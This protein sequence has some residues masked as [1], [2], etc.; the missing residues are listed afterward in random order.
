MPCFPPPN[1]DPGEPEVQRLEK[2]DESYDQACAGV[3]MKLSM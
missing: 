3:V 1:M 2:N